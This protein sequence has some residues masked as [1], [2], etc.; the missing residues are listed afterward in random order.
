MADEITLDITGT[1]ELQQQLKALGESVRPD[2]V[3]PLLLEGAKTVRDTAI[4]LAPVGP[5]G[6]LKKS[7]V[8]KMLPSREFGKPGKAI[9]ALDRKK[10]PHAWLV[11]FGSHGERISKRGKS[12]GVMPANPFF[13]NAWDSTKDWV[14]GHIIE[15][16]K[17]LIEGSVK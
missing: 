2:R 8:A 5:T 1:D 3:E 6:N 17:D 10:A 16:L 14:L 4:N 15:G 13:R 12:S 9:A 7:P 11:E